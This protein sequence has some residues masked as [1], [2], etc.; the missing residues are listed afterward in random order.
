MSNHVFNKF[1]NAQTIC[2]QLYEWCTAGFRAGF[3]IRINGGSYSDLTEHSDWRDGKNAGFNEAEKLIKKGKIFFVYPFECE[4]EGCPT[5]FQYGG[6][7]A[8]NSCNTHINTPDWWKIK[9]TQ[10]GNKYCCIGDGFTNLQESNNYAFG[11]SFQDAINQYYHS[12]YAEI[13]DKS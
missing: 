10:D 12:H 3:S 4:R 7:W 6:Y 1:E 11:D 8:C 9:V 2:E 13:L 5:R